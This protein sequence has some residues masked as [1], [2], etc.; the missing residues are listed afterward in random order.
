MTTESKVGKLGDIK[1]IIKDG[2]KVAVG[3]SWLG[4]HPMAIIREIIRSNIKNLTAITVVGSIDIDLLVGA[5]CL[6]RLMFS[7][8]SMEAFGLAPNFRR[9][10]EKEGLPYDEITGLA[11]II[12]LEAGGRNMPFLP[13]R[14]PFGSDLVKYRPE[15]YKEIKCPFTGEALIA[16][17]A[18]VPDVAIIHATRADHTGNVQI[19][20]TSGTDVEM[21]RAAKKRIVSVEEIVSPEEIRRNPY[22]TKIPKFQVDMVIEAPMGAHPC[23]CAPS[24]VFDPWHIM[25]YM[26]AAAS[27][28]TFQQYLDHYVKKPEWE[29]LEAIGGIKQASILRR[30]A[31]EVKFL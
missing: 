17:A 11:V 21:M 15:F 30:L 29:Y 1:K 27:P 6:S 31:R 3:G 25:Q 9:A 13:Y 10:I 22:K 14:G 26:Q 23:A 19:E 12:G 4:G 16:A 20:G 5:G 8:V 2:D 7:F 28:E 24:Y 18:I